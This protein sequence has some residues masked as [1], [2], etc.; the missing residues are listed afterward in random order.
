MMLK[1]TF[2]LL[3]AVVSV[4]TLAGVVQAIPSGPGGIGDTSGTSE[5]RL[6][7]RADQGAL[8]AGSTS[9]TDTQGVATLLDQSGYG[10]HATQSITARQ[11]IFDA[12]AVNS[13]L[14]VLTFDG[15]ASSGQGQYL[16]MPHFMD[17]SETTI[18][19]IGRR[20][21]GGVGTAFSMGGHNGTDSQ[22]KI[23]FRWHSSNLNWIGVG[24]ADAEQLQSIPASPST[25]FSVDSINIEEQTLTVNSNHATLATDTNPLFVPTNFNTNRAP[26]I[27]RDSEIT[28]YNLTGEIA[29]IIVFDHALNDLERLMIDNALA[30]KYD[31]SGLSVANDKYNGDEATQGD[32]D[33]DV[34][35][36]GNDGT[37]S[38]LESASAGLEISAT[39][40]DAGE[41]AMSGHNTLVNSVVM[42]GDEYMLE[43]DFYIDVTGAFEATL[44]FDFDELGVGTSSAFDRLLYSATE[45]GP[46]TALQTVAMYSGNQVSFALT[47][48]QFVDGY[49]T[50]AGQ[51][52]EPSSFALLGLGLALIARRRR[53][54]A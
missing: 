18:Y 5:L 32:Y 36:I 4:F 48:G 42:A 11:P 3:L 34:F 23:Q 24:G 14:P 30:A 47:S 21:G 49:Y 8:N 46:F 10:N 39:G 25:V 50:I 9:A 54:A 12:N 28:S 22:P 1:T 13:I 31:I 16:E 40:L 19:A 51:V 26:R 20:T 53:K 6:W 27:G 15:T 44:T 35:G 45:G 38:I 2:S 43:R 41:Y 29:E 37:N 33:F 52:P 17:F 7:L